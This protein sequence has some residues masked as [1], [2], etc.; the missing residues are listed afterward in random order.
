ME[1]IFLSVCT[2][3]LANVTPVNSNTYEVVKIVF[4]II[5][6]FWFKRL[7]NGKKNKL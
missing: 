1:L 3:L 2:L 7:N 6:L 4:F 5:F